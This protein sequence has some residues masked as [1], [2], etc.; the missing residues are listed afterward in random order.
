MIYYP[1]VQKNDR[2]MATPG[3]LQLPDFYMEDFSILGFR[4]NDCDQAIRL[5][6]QHDFSLKW[7]DGSIEVA[8]ERVSRVHDVMQLLNDSGLE[9]EIADV[10]DGMY[11]G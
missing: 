11:Q 2:P 1:I 7:T 6:G 9:C 3:Q 10:A 8:I 5:L 4:V